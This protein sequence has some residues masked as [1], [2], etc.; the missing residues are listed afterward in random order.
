[1]QFK[2][3]FCWC[4][5]L[6]VVSAANNSDWSIPGLLSSVAF[7]YGDL[8]TVFTLQSIY[9]AFGKKGFWKWDE[10]C[11][12]VSGVMYQDRWTDTVLGNARHLICDCLVNSEEEI[13]HLSVTW[14]QRDSKEA[15]KTCWKFK[16]R[17]VY[18]YKYTC[19]HTNAHSYTNMNS[20]EH[21]HANIHAHSDT[22]NNK[23]I[24]AI[25]WTN[26]L[27]KYTVCCN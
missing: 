1:M 2:C 14:N 12:F 3:N 21:V 17:T 15:V 11:V 25:I 19:T 7:L 23:Q 26:T 5:S 8:L 10:L 22:N 20:C 9:E 24:R 4:L 16:R 27:D 18:T 6:S 13:K